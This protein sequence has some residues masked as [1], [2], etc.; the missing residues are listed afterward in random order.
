[1]SKMEIDTDVL[2]QLLKQVTT[3]ENKKRRE[4][5]YEMHPI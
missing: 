2:Q 5:S 4:G 3:N 1:M